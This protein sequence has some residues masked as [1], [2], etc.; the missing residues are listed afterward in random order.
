[1]DS[2]PGRL[3]VFSDIVRK[4]WVIRT[5]Y[6]FYD[7]AP[8]FIKSYLLILYGLKC[9][10]SA[11]W[12]GSPEADIAVCAVYPNERVAMAHIRRNLQGLTVGEIALSRGNCF[13][14]QS[15]QALPAFFCQA[16]R[17]QRVARRLVRRFHFL[18]ACRI[19]S[20]MTYYARYRRLLAM[21]E[22]KAVFIANHYSPECLALAA[23]AHASHRKVFS[24]NHAN[25]T[26]R[27][28]YVPPLYGDLIVVTSAAIL[29]A[30]AKHSDQALNSVFIPQALPQRP[31]RNCVGLGRPITVGVF[32]TA[33]TNMERLRSL[34]A[35]LQSDSKVA[36]VVIRSHPVK[37]VNEDLTELLASGDK[38]TESSA[39]SLPENA[40]LC[41]AAICGNSTVTIDILRGG[42]PVF[43]DG[44]LDEL[45]HDLNGYVSQGLIPPLPPRLDAEALKS[46]GGFY[47]SPS[48]ETTMRHFDAGY[49]QDED[50][51]FQRLND[52][53]HRK[54]RVSA[55]ADA[56]VYP[57]DVPGEVP[58]PATT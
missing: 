49:Q 39:L 10:L 51:M 11:N 32:L 14:L 58:Y 37:V 42:L 16:A 33:L 3:T 19:F 54:I 52:A 30:Y 45:A 23:A 17:L 38:V 57:D 27:S 50:A 24:T 8:E 5:A 12:L 36:R 7:R 15:W 55:S 4:N 1:M 40:A 35:Q 9:Y 18:P 56:R 41:D 43:Y 28:G 53:L 6:F 29:D 47:G 22:S 44:E 48:W 25:G 31:M 26:W 46:L 2:S 20:T 34:V 13:R 21:G